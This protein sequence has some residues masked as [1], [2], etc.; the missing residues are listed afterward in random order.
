MFPLCLVGHK[1]MNEL[2]MV[3]PAVHVYEDG[4]WSLHSLNCTE[5][6][7]WPCPSSIYQ[8]EWHVHVHVYIKYTCC[9]KV[10]KSNLSQDKNVHVQGVKDRNT[11]VH[12]KSPQQPFCEL[13]HY[14][15]TRYQTR[16]HYGDQT[17]ILV[18]LTHEDY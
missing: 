9:K 5:I 13:V 11:H 10:L 12:T 14:M 17:R 2:V 4:R 7:R 15:L 3:T 18:W 16:H 1:T 6:T 8:T